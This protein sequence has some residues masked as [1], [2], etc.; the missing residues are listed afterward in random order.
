[1]L[2][3]MSI[4]QLARVKMHQGKLNVARKLFEE[5]LGLSADHQ[6]R[7]LPIA[8]EALMGLGELLREINQLKEATDGS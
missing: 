1:M 4:C 2:L 3:V 8:G 7:F 6:S 5:A